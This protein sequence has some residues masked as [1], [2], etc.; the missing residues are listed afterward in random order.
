MGFTHGYSGSVPLGRWWY[1]QDA[2]TVELREA[3]ELL[4]EMSAAV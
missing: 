4:A 1:C 2:P 3:Q